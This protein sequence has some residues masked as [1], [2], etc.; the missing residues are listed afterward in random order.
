MT[1]TGNTAAMFGLSRRQEI[2][3]RIVQFLKEHY[4]QV[5]AATIPAAARPG[6][7]PLAILFRREV[8]DPDFLC[9]EIEARLEKIA[10]VPFALTFLGPAATP[11][12]AGLLRSGQLILDRDPRFRA[13]YTWAAAK[14]LP[15]SLTSGRRIIKE[16]IAANA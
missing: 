1:H 8:S 2:V 4:P 5:A 11:D 3:A 12:E 15:G 6:E 13:D 16:E 14:R 9:A 10:D 7:I